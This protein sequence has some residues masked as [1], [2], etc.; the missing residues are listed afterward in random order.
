[1]NE[2][3]ENIENIS[4]RRISYEVPSPLRVFARHVWSNRDNDDII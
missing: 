2:N 3:I 4:K 1:M